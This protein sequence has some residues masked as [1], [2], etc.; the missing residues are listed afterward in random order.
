MCWWERRQKLMLFSVLADPRDGECLS[1]L[2][3]LLLTG[4]L[5]VPID[6]LH[7]IIHVIQTICHAFVGCCPDL[8]DLKTMLGVDNEATA[9]DETIYVCS[10]HLMS[11]DPRRS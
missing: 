1:N 7:A 8:D 6:I 11:Y 10:V 4:S 3:P 5:A 9:D 2:R